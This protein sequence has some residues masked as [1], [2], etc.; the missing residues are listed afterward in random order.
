MSLTAVKKHLKLA[1]AAGW[2]KRT[3][4]PK[5]GRGYNLT[6]YK[7]RFPIPVED[8]NKES[9]DDHIKNTGS[10]DDCEGVV[11]QLGV[12]RHTTKLGSPDTPEHN[13]YITTNITENI[14]VFKKVLDGQ[15]SVVE[16][17]QVLGKDRK[18]I[19]VHEDL[20]YV[21]FGRKVSN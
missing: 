10:L 2:I 3:A 18:E 4:G 12:G 8:T 9:P 19:F 14:T 17:I 1:E 21:F 13:R 15:T 7:G 20:D 16:N 5:V 6:K 11:T